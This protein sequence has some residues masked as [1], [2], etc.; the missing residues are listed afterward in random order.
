MGLKRKKKLNEKEESE[1]HSMFC[2]TGKGPSMVMGTGTNTNQF[3]YK[4]MVE[5]QSQSAS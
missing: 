1:M 3:T 4:C 5:C 2:D